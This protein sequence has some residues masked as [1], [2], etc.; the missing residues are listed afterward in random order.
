MT[1]TVESGPI[2]GVPAGGLSFGASSN[3]EAIVPQP[4]QFDFYDGGGLDVAV[5]GMAEADRFGNVNVSKFG[6]RIAARR[7][8]QHQS[9]R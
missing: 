1:L 5:L 9:K 4:S 6:P 2:G 7:V 8:S 3:P